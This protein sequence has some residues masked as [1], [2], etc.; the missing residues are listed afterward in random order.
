MQRRSKL[1]FVASPNPVAAGR[2]V[3][4]LGRLTAADRET[5]A[6]TGSAGHPV[7]L[8]FCASPCRTVE[9]VRSLTTGASG[10]TGTSEP[11]RGT[12]RGG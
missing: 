5:D 3:G 12:V 11:S 8:E 2:D 7:A 4:M 6:Y 1:T 10:I 9:P